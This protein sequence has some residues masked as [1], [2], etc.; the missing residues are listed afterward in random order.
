MKAVGVWQVEKD[1]VARLEPASLSLEREL[2]EWIE[3]NPSLLESGLEIVGRQIR[4]EGGMIDLLALDL[5]G[6]WVVIEIKKGNLHRDAVAQALDYASCIEKLGF[7]KLWGK[8]S[9]Y[10]KSVGPENNKSEET[11]RDRVQR[12]GTDKK[13]RE[14]VVYVVGTGQDPSLERILGF[15][16]KSQRVVH[17]VLFSV[18]E[19]DSSHRLLVRELTSN[20]PP[21]SGARQKN[22][23][24]AGVIKIAHDNGLGEAF[25]S[26]VAAA[27]RHGLYP[28][29]FKRSI[30][31]APANN[32]TRCLFVAWVKPP[33]DYVMKLYVVPDAFQEFYALRKELVVKE[34]GNAGYR[35]LPVSEV[36]EFVRSLDRLMSSVEQRSASGS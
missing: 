5:Q 12:E 36:P 17:A 16:D 13:D 4:V 30:M 23:S 29:P 35:Q 3:R 19:S 24:L 22:L 14:V 26:L 1:R 9:D 33:A 31:F 28:R 8:V 11:L 15:V 2:E 7:E 6:R 34:L 10:L 21:G 18:F 27:E 32:R 25:E 20:P